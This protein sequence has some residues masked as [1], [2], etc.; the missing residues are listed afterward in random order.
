[1]SGGMSGGEASDTWADR[2]RQPG[3]AVPLGTLADVRIVTGPPMIKNE[4][5]VLVG[6][7]FADVDGSQ[8]DLGGWVSDARRL[9]EAEVSLPA[10]YRLQWTGQYEFMADM[11]A[12]LLV[13]VPLTLAIIVML[14]FLALRSWG[15]TALVLA[16]IPLA[17]VGGIWLMAS[18]HYNLSTAV[19]VGLIALGGVSA[20]TAIVVVVYL[21]QAFREAQSEGRLSLPGGLEA[22]VVEGATRGVR[23]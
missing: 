4:N 19:W 18:L 2:W 9:V 11:Q 8:R 22:A 21:E 23:R 5:G 20:Q 7:V 3:A 15:Q 13:I 1:M 17:V 16:S 10:G 14:L 12:R 6:Y